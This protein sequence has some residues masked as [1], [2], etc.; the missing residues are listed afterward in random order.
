MAE[1]RH[2]NRERILA[3]IERMME[4]RISVDYWNALA[5]IRERILEAR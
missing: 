3:E 5:Q 4:T 1:Y 2:R